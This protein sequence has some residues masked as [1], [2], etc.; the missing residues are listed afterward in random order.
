VVLHKHIP[1]KFNPIST[2]TWYFSGIIHPNSAMPSDRLRNV[3]SRMRS[4]SAE[5]GKESV[6]EATDGPLNT[7]FNGLNIFY[8]GERN[9]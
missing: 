6:N 3:F 2:I 7:A 9:H 1:D 8:D 4:R 5:K